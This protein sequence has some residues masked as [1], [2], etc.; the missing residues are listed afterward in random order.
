MP[1]DRFMPRPSSVPPYGKKGRSVP[2]PS[3]RGLARQAEAV[4]RWLCW[5][6]AAA[7]AVLFRSAVR[8]SRHGLLNRRQ[9]L[10]LV[11]W[12]THLHR[13]AIR[14]LRQGRW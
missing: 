11:R 10:R 4:D 9:T 5:A 1:V 6:F 7:G 13:V 8:L 12:S 14:L 3:S 2:H